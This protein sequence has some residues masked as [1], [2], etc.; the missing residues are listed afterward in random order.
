ML[1]FNVMRR[2]LLAV[3]PLLVLTSCV[4]TSQ[5]TI[6]GAMTYFRVEGGP[7]ILVR[8]GYIRLFAEGDTTTPLATFQT[9]ELGRFNL[10]VEEGNYLLSGAIADTGPFSGTVG[11]FAV[12]GHAT[13]R[14]FLAIDTPAPNAPIAGEITPTGEIGVAGSQVTFAVTAM[15]TIDEGAPTGWRWNF[16]EGAEPMLSSEKNPIVTLREPGT[17]TGSVIVFNAQGTSAPKTF[18]FVVLPAAD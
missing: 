1:L 15:S 11:P 18:D 10:E 6:L 2:A 7:S 3:I 12:G 13:T 9:D 17:Y 14:L 8:D 4:D 5:G 16:G